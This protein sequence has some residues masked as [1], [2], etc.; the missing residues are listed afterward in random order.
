MGDINNVEV[1]VDAGGAFWVVAGIALCFLLVYWW[2]T[3]NKVSIER[4]YYTLH[5]NEH[6]I[7][8]ARAIQQEQ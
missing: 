5:V 2:G 8:Q 1:N 4:A 7:E 3:T 6:A